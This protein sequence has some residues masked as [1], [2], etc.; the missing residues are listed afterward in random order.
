MTS[1]RLSEENGSSIFVSFDSLGN[2]EID[3]PCSSVT[4]ES[5]TEISSSICFS[6]SNLF[7]ILAW[8][9]FP[10]LLVNFIFWAPQNEETSISSISVPL[11]KLINVV[12]YFFNIFTA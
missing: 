8:E 4:S 1:C 3:M 12:I 2:S 7:L 5:A 6:L 10:L 9:Y 11:I